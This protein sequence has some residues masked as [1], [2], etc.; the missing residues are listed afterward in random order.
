MSDIMSILQSSYSSAASTQSLISPGDK[1]AAVD[2]TQYQG[3]WTG[4]DFNNQPISIS[5]TKVSGYRANVTMQ[6]ADGLQFQ[7]ALITTKGTFRIGNSQFTLTGTGK[8]EVD[9]IE[10][11][12]TTGIQTDNKATLTLQS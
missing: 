11:D 10:T 5:I 7:R 12:P 6:S 8:A 2:P 1:F 3:T 4:K 9:T